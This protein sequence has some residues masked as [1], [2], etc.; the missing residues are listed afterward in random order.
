MTDA[1]REVA[2]K[3]SGHYDLK[4]S[5]LAIVLKDADKLVQTFAFTGIYVYVCW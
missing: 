2:T 4:E 5:Q 3:V 1:L